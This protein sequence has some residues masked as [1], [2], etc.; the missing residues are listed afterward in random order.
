MMA[1]KQSEITSFLK[2]SGRSSVFSSEHTCFPEGAGVST[3]TFDSS[4][5][6]VT[7]HRR[8]AKPAENRNDGIDFETSILSK[9]D[10][11]A[12]DPI[13]DANNQESIELSLAV[14][15]SR[16]TV[17]LETPRKEVYL[18]KKPGQ[19]RVSGQYFLELGQ[20]DFFL[21][22]C[23]VCGLQYSRG[24][25]EDEKVHKSFH[26]KHLQGV[27][28]KGWHNERIVNL[29]DGDDRIILV[30]NSD[31]SHHQHKEVVAIMEKE[32]GLTKEW[33]LHRF[34]KVYLFIS[35]KKIIGCLVSE[36]INYGY[37]TVPEKSLTNSKEKHCNIVDGTPKEISDDFKDESTLTTTSASPNVS[38]TKNENQKIIDNENDA[39]R[40][41]HTCTVMQFGNIKF[42]R[43]TF[44][45][46]RATRDSSISEK[47][48][49][50]AIVCS[51]VPEPAVCGVRGIWVSRSERR[52]GIA[53]KLLDTMRRTFSL[54]YVLEP[55]KCAFSQPTFDGKAFAANYCKTDLFLIYKT[56]INET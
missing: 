15:H 48:Q 26:R 3:S 40:R 18:E 41:K 12:K 27:Q 50:G 29:F 28:F 37:R 43:K 2:P 17:V 39:K 16:P 51:E 30:L 20:P 31:P 38:Y 42:E 1:L 25:D 47:D 23:I 53:T 4:K 21:S 33:L 54:G 46:T 8:T 19:K 11:F 56:G 22:T 52:K 36:P 35:S 13:K 55:C 9:E 32:M 10:T 49:R 34:C 6:S 44:K 7:Y 45:N 14:T 5:I 24:D